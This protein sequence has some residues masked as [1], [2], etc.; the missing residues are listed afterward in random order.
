MTMA[1]DS[2]EL[3]GSETIVEMARLGG[4]SDAVFAVALTLLVLD[5]RIP[6]AATLADLPDRMLEL[7]PRPLVYLIGFIIIG[8]A[9]GS[10]QR[11]IALSGEKVRCRQTRIL[12]EGGTRSEHG[13]QR[14]PKRQS[15]YRRNSPDSMSSGHPGSSPR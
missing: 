12:A 8:G 7:L 11:P 10:H 9:W 5:I 3:A 13:R 6:E 1:D 15:I 4:L 14:C 2:Q